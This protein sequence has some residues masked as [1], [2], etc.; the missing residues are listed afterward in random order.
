MSTVI[1]IFTNYHGPDFATFTPAAEAAMRSEM[2]ELLQQP[3]LT[4]AGAVE[5]VFLAQRRIYHDDPES[6]AF[7]SEVRWHA[8]RYLAARSALTFD[9]LWNAYLNSDGQL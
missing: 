6:G 1:S 8:Y 7:D 2:D 3:A 9:D 4:A 5:G